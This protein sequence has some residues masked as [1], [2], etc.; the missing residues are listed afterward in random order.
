MHH[1]HYQHLNAPP[2]HNSCMHPQHTHTPSQPQLCAGIVSTH[3]RCCRTEPRTLPH[4]APLASMPGHACGDMG[5]ASAGAASELVIRTAPGSAALAAAARRCCRT[6]AA[7]A[8]TAALPSTS[9]TTSSNCCCITAWLKQHLLLGPSSIQQ[10]I[11]NAEGS[12]WGLAATRAPWQPGLSAQTE[13]LQTFATQRR[14]PAAAGAA[15]RYCVFKECV[16]QRA[17]RFFCFGKT[18]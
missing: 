6:G 9:R 12:A 2:S 18:T 5:T 14:E 13:R 8:S 4:T 10:T 1:H 11:S 17:E 16:Q 15:F 7:A 3:P